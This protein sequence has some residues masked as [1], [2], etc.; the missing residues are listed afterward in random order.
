LYK[1]AQPWPVEC[2]GQKVGVISSAVYSP[3][4][5]K[6]VAMAMVGI[7]CAEVGTQVFVDMGEGKTEATVV[8]MPFIDNREKVWRGA[9]D[10]KK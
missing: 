8:N 9:D 10:K 7:K 5:D 2:D 1:L 4:L 6:N 3:D